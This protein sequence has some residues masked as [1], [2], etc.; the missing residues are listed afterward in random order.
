LS[1]GDLK[2]TYRTYLSNV[3]SYNTQLTLNSM[4]SM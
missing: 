2:Y 4:L 1:G 3:I